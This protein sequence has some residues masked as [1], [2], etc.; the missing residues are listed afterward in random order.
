[1]QRLEE[2]LELTKQDL[3]DADMALIQVVQLQQMAMDFASKMQATRTE[4]LEPQ[5]RTN[6]MDRKTNK[7]PTKSSLCGCG[8]VFMAGDGVGAKTTP[9]EYNNVIKSMMVGC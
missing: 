1:M 9:E 6:L 5:Q 4:M 3:L 8:H 7:G 2:I